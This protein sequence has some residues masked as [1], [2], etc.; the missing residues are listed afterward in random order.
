VTASTSTEGILEARG[1]S[2]QFGGLKAINT[3][4]VTVSAG[5]IFSIIGPNGAGKTTLFN[6]LTGFYAPSAGEIHFEGENIA[7]LRPDLITRRGIARTF[8]NV[9][10][11]GE[12]TA[13]ENV[14]VAQHCRTRAGALAALLGTPG[15][16]REDREAARR[17]LE[18]LQFVGLGGKADAWARNLAYGEQRRLEIARA[19]ATGP[20][21]LLLDEPAAGMNPTEIGAIMELIQRIRARGVTVVLIEHHMKMVMGISDRIAVLDHGEKIAEGTPADVSADARVVEA[22]LGK[23]YDDATAQH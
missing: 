4:S 15:A 10:L 11:F 9:R 12:M 23:T 16:A 5:Q 22:Y 17:A 13:L 8:Q 18:E 21:L 6:C 7:G 3:V 20:K 1:L 2:R 19:L 14:M